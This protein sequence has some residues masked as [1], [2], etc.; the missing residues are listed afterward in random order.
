[1]NICPF[2]LETMQGTPLPITH[3]FFNIIYADYGLMPVCLSAYIKCFNN[4][5][6]EWSFPKVKQ[7]LAH[8]MQ[9]WIE[10]LNIFLCNGRKTIEV[11]L[12]KNVRVI[13]PQYYFAC[14]TLRFPSL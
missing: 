10:I 8:Y 6:F 3:K 12:G 14:A 1:V 4:C 7:V 9:S 13:R 11:A 2:K 5:S